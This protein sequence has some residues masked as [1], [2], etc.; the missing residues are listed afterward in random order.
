MYLEKLVLKNFRN[1]EDVNKDFLAQINILVGS[2]AQG[3]TN[4]LES[5]NYLA[6]GKSY[7]PAR[8]AQ[9]IQW[10]KDFFYVAGKIK[11]RLGSTGIEITFKTDQKSLKEI[12]VNGLKINKLSEL[13]GNL[14]TVLFAPEDLNIIK[15]SPAERRRLLDNDISQANPGYYVRLQQYNRILSQRNNLLKKMEHRPK[16]KE[17]LEVWDQQLLAAGNDIIKKRLTVLGK[18]SPLTRLVQRKLTDG[19]EN[20]EIKYVINK[21][22]E[23]EKESDVEKILKEEMLRYKNDEIKRGM[24]LWGPH[25][26]DLK[27]SIN[28]NDLK[29]YGSQGQHRTSVL[30]IKLAEL[31]FFKAE[32]GEYPLLLLDDVMSELDVNRRTQLINT[33]RER[34]I[35]CFITST[36]DIPVDWG[37]N[38]SVKRLY[39]ERGRVMEN[40]N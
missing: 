14:T 30:A 10:K 35:Q 26:D 33:I 20:L 7:R 21:E 40:K 8:E 18:L 39:I 28:G 36:E 38:T 3:K 1:Y 34:A 12:K 9:L 17:Q 31:E 32:S 37:R 25:R 13:L 16:S 23:V 24:S 15:G 2:N 6:T 22:I 19:E 29:Y 4:L 11:S 27:F 5:I